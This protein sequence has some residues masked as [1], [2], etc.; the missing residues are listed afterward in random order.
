MDCAIKIKHTFFV[1]ILCVV[2]N[3]LTAQNLIENSL[4]ND[5]FD[6]Y[7]L[8][9]NIGVC[10]HPSFSGGSHK[11]WA[12]GG[13]YHL[14]HGDSGQFQLWAPY[15][16]RFTPGGSHM[17]A[18]KRGLGYGN[19]ITLQCGPDYPEFPVFRS[20]NRC[21]RSRQ[22]INYS[23]LNLEKDSLYVVEFFY[24][25]NPFARFQSRNLTY[26]FYSDSVSLHDSIVVTKVND[27]LDEYPSYDEWKHHRSFF[28]STGEEMTLFFNGEGLD[29]LIKQTDSLRIP[30]Y[31]PSPIRGHHNMHWRS[32][33]TLIDDVHLYKASDTMFTV[34]LPEDTVLCLG[35][36]LWLHAEPEGFKLEDTVTTYEWSTGET[37]QS[38]KVTETGEYWVEVRINHTYWAR[39]TIVVEFE[40]Y[41]EWPKP[42]GDILEQCNDVGSSW[43]E[44]NGPELKHG[45]L[46]FWSTGSDEQTAYVSEPGFYWLEVQTPCYTESDTFELKQINCI[47]SDP[48]IP[49][50]FTP[51]GHNPLWIIGG[52]E[53]GARVEVFDRWGQRVFHSEDYHNN[54]WDGTY[55]GAPLPTGVYTYR[56]VAP[57]EGRD[58]YDEIG[59][60]TIVR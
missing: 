19:I 27:V 36:S 15:A 48:Y 11:K 46:Y 44:V 24:R 21:G 23:N 35:D 2:G 13:G 37:T 31:F 34:T 5:I 40:P 32:A 39:D 49:S 42:F 28:T 43:E 41:P 30:P 47:E 17:P 7:Y 60:V 57:R 3:C 26:G 50:A 6:V 45:G 25:T 38:I 55:N 4:F 14:C 33:G 54:W 29:S 52:L 9:S 58:P 22:F 16:Y 51:G 12:N 10:P 59:T 56:I 1:I 53:Q 18:T 20:I 8:G